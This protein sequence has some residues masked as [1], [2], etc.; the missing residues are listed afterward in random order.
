MRPVTINN[1]FVMR[2]W[3]DIRGADLANRE[4]EAGIRSSQ[5]DVQRLIER[6]VERGLQRSRLVLAGF[7]Q[8]AAITLQTGLRQAEPLAG[9]VA[10]SG[11]LPLAEQFAAERHAGSHGVPILMAHGTQ[12]P[13]VEIARGRASRDLLLR[14]GHPVQWH[15]YPM[16]HSVS[17]EELEAIAT[18]LRDRLG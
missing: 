15:E 2:A 14:L 10:L 9:L 13:V 16:R 17:A 11:Y 12:D 3:Y 1:G 18:F 4:D 8:G 7:S 6:E 5:A